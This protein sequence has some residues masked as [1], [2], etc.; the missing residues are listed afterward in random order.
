MPA[1]GGI[2]A[3]LSAFHSRRDVANDRAAPLMLRDAW[4]TMSIT[5]I[6]FNKTGMRSALLGRARAPWRAA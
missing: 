3:A 4:Q 6:V 5:Q 2:E 1:E